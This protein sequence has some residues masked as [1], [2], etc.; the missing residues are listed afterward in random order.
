SASIVR[1]TAKR[2]LSVTVDYKVSGVNHYR[3]ASKGGF[4]VQVTNLEDLKEF[5]ASDFIKKELAVAEHFKLLLITFEPGQEVQPCVMERSTAFYIVEGQGKVLA[6]EQEHDITK[7]SMVQIEPDLTRQIIAN[8][9]LV[10][11]AMQYE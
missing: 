1:P 3:I 8:S 2:A 9:R 7:G 11:L 5:S 4:L 10:V 6:S